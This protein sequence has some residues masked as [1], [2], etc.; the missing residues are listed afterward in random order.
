MEAAAK[1][2]LFNQASRSGD[3][4]AI[5]VAATSL[6]VQ[7]GMPAPR[8]KS[9]PAYL[10]VK[11][12]LDLVSR[13][14]AVNEYNKKEA[15]VEA[16]IL[17]E[18]EAIKTGQLKRMEAVAQAAFLGKEFSNGKSGKDA[19][20]DQRISAT[21]SLINN[22]PSFFGSQ[23]NVMAAADFI[24]K[25]YLADKKSFDPNAVYAEFMSSGFA[26]SEAAYTNRQ[27]NLHIEGNGLLKPGANF[28]AQMEERKSVLI[29]MTNQMFTKLNQPAKTQAEYEDLMN[30]KA[31]FVAGLRKELS[32]IRR[33]VNTLNNDPAIRTNVTGYDYQSSLRDMEIL[34]NSIQQIEKFNPVMPSGMAA[35]NQPRN[36]D[37]VQASLNETTR[38]PDEAGARMNG[39]QPAPKV[40]RDFWGNPI[41]Q[42]PQQPSDFWG[43]DK[44]G[45][46][47]DFLGNPKYSVEEQP[48]T[49]T[50]VTPL[51]YE[52]VVTSG[53]NVPRS[54]MDTYLDAV[55]DVESSGDPFAR[56]A[57]S[58]ATGLFQFTKGTWNSL[59][60][61]FGERLGVSK[62]DIFNPNAQR[63]MAQV[64]TTL[65]AEQLIRQTGRQPSEGDLYLAHF[66]GPA[67][68]ATVINH[69]GSSL[70]AANLFPDA[71][72]AN[73]GIFYKDG[74]PVTVEELY[75]NMSSKVKRRIKST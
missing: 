28:K 75:K 7:A 74:V 42:G 19:A 54:R 4:D 73:R 3:E 71:A 39:A 67:R 52:S 18:N 38:K 70:L 72:K 5:F 66:L 35:P 22:D 46:P 44:N 37:E 53:T 1:S 27:K 50:V 57:T 10:A 15:D 26:E 30:K 56:A 68:A 63:I 49:V 11:K 43:R 64:L 23:N 33:S 60:E 65:N 40:E 32:D 62:E 47:V 29:D 9:D 24:K 69:Q 20:V 14:A 36:L 2:D 48:Q 34:E 25:K 51:S 61:R 41:K 12:S 55:A 21:L 8:D 6:M 31:R 59:V 45:V 13:T 58:S 17:K 16:A